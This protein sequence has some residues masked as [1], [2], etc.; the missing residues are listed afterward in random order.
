MTISALDLLDGVKRRVLIPAQGLSDDDILKFADEVI[1]NDIVNLMISINQDFFVRFVEIPLVP[2]QTEYD[3]PYR[4]IGR[5]LREIKLKDSSTFLRNVPM[6]SIE[7]ASG[8]FQFTQTV[9][10]YFRGDK[11]HLVP[12]VPDTPVPD[13]QLAIWYPLAPSSLMIPNQLNADDPTVLDYF[14]SEVVRVDTS[15]NATETLVAVDGVIEL[16]KDGDLIDLVQGKSGSDIYDFDIPVLRFFDKVET[17]ATVVVSGASPWLV[18]V[19]L[20]SHGLETGNIIDV[21]NAGPLTGTEE[22]LEGLQTITVTGPN[23]FTYTVDNDPGA[24]TSIDY[25]CQNYVFLDNDPVFSRMVQGDYVTPPQQSPV[26]NFVPN[27][28]FNLLET[29]TARLVVQSISDYEG[30]KVLEKDAMEYKKIIKE[31]LQPRIEGEPTII[32]N[33]WSLSR[34]RTRSQRSWLYGS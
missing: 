32:T 6:I 12:D 20:A 21:S 4:A 30:M 23:T 3:I 13:R 1:S 2:G 7:N 18:T 34:N 22:D 10:F 8:F 26:V 16:T 28:V 17:G 25:S 29:L 27:E 24:V 19:T 9:G 15:F 5:T 11:I 14:A 33:P 31:L